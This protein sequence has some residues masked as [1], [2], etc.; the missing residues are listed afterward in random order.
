MTVVLTDVSTELKNSFHF[1][2]TRCYSNYSNDNTTAPKQTTPTKLDEIKADDE[3]KDPEPPVQPRDN[4]DAPRGNDDSATRQQD[5]TRHDAGRICNKYRRREC[6]HGAN[7]KTLIN[8]KHCEFA[9]P[10]RCRKYCHNGTHPKSGC[11]KTNCEYLHPVLCR[12][13]ARNRVCTNLDCKFTHLKFTRR[14]DPYQNSQDSTNSTTYYPQQPE[15]NQQT[16]TSPQYAD[17]RQQT[18]PTQHTQPTQQPPHAQQADVSLFSENDTASQRRAS[19]AND[20][21]ESEAGI[22][23]TANPSTTGPDATTKHAD[24]QATST[25]PSHTH[26]ST[27][28]SK[29][30]AASTVVASTYIM[31]NF[32]GMSPSATSQS[33]WK[34]PFFRD[35]Y[36]TDS[37]KYIP[38]IAAT[39]TWLKPHVTDAQISIPNYTSI[40]ADRVKSDR[41]G[42]LLYIHND[43]PVTNISK[44]D[45]DVCEA[46]L[47]TLESSNTIIA[48]IYRPPS[49]SSDTFKPVMQ[50][51]QKYINTQTASKHYDIMLMGD[52]NLPAI[53]WDT[54]N[55]TN[56]ASSEANKSAD[57]LLN[58]MAVNFMSQCIRHPT[59]AQNTL[60]LLITNNTNSIV[61]TSAEDTSLSDHDLVFITAEFK[62]NSQS[63]ILNKKLPSHSFRTLKLHDVDYEQID[64]QL[65]E[66]DWDALISCCTQEEFPELLYLTVLQVCELHCE[67][68]K[69][70]NKNKLNRERRVLKRK[71][72]KLKAKRQA[73]LNSNPKSKTLDDIRD[74]IYLIEDQIKETI[75][76]QQRL[77]EEKVVETLK[78]NPSYFYSYA[79][80]ASK[81]YSKV[82][83]LFDKDTKLQSDHKVMADLLQHQYTS[84]FSDPN[85]ADKKLP[86]IIINCENSIG[87]IE[88]SR[89][90]IIS[91]INE[92][93]ENAACGEDDIPA[94]VL[95]NCKNS[96]SYPIMCIW[97]ESMLTSIIPAKYKYQTITPIHKKDSKAIAANYRPISLTSHIIKIYERVIRKKIVKYLEENKLLF[98]NQHGFRAQRSCLT[99]LLAH[100]D[101]ILNNQL[102]NMDTDVVYL[103]FEKAFDKV[104]HQILLTKLK[105]YN[106]NG[107]LH[108]WLTEY[109]HN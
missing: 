82:G 109:L 2:C 53:S 94:I 32:Q 96:L 74:E 49:A 107:K 22:P 81:T 31:L 1:F 105:G 26:N 98:R 21:N 41:G 9:H 66:I 83:P 72:V 57:I 28:T 17:S 87:D 52:F 103:D 40:R 5:E 80:R 46:V 15:I 89:D 33:R 71:R 27:T 67:T 101:R 75:K 42:T 13:S 18:Q 12:Y 7:G 90:D 16:Y 47:C 4:T 65:S 99:Q 44:Y 63:A 100:I 61:H 76:N 54:I 73:V 48:S 23:P 56:Y 8:G 14:Y 58:F 69:V 64:E 55:I 35:E 34:I 86:E 30:A 77:K 68:K 106:I 19:N 91:A 45:N 36:L 24:T 108:E 95:K 50:F 102:I 10:R 93:N 62:T 97:K 37:D 20:R 84:V 79:K 85:S 25:I 38:F 92:I 39:E 3:S 43:I 6:P 11:T 51:I 60:D 104:D 29:D 88:F 70:T 59:R 78:T